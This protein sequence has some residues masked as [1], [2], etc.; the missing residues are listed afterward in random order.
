MNHDT[1][2]ILALEIVDKREVSLKSANMEKMALQRGIDNIQQFGLC[3]KELVTDGHS[4]IAAM[5]S[6]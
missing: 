3:I 2:D 1:N 6:T 4:Q 5:M